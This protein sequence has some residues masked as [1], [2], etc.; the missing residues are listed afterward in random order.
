MKP[1]THKHLET[2]FLKAS[3]AAARKRIY[4]LRAAQD[5]HE[6]MAKLFDAMAISEEA[7][8][9]RFL[10]QLRGQTKKTE[11]NIHTA[12]SHE[13]PA[14]IEEYTDA[15]SAAESEDER[16]MAAAFSQSSRVEK[17]YLSLQKKLNPSDQ[18]G[19]YHICSFC[20]FIKE[21]QIPERC[22]ICTAAPN[23][24]VTV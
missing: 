2:A 10:L 21:K 23:R 18:A 3:R 1:Q 22:P 17:L 5:G 7:Q 8:A 15:A 19:S 16:A 4:S 12:I 20:G 13:I 11:E 9:R 14:L 6:Q 24:F